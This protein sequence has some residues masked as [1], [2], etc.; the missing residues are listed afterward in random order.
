MRDDRDL[1]DPDFANAHNIIREA[2][3]GDRRARP[4]LQ[5]TLALLLSFGALALVIGAM[6]AGVL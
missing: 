5:V 3:A 4:R 6:Q 2:L 1:V